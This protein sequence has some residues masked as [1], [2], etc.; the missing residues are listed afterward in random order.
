MFLKFDMRQGANNT[1][2]IDF[3]HKFS[4]RIFDTYDHL[5]ACWFPLRI[6]LMSFLSDL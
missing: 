2:G 4:L 3:N 5:D 1:L 6:M